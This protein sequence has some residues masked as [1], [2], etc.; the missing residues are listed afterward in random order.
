VTEAFNPYRQ[1]LDLTVSE[2][3]SSDYELLGLK[4]YETDPAVIL[5]AADRAIARVRSHRPGDQAAAWSRLLDDLAAARKRL[6]DPGEKARYDEQLRSQGGSLASPGEAKPISEPSKSQANDFRYPPG[7]SGPGMPVTTGNAALGGGAGLNNG[8]YSAVANAGV[9]VQQPISTPQASYPQQ[10]TPQLAAPWG[11]PPYAPMPSGFPAAAAYPQPMQPMGGMPGYG[12]PAAPQGSYGQSYNPQG[13]YAPGGHPQAMPM[14]APGWP[15]PGA[16]STPMPPP[17]APPAPSSTA[18]PS[19]LATPV[20]TII[21]PMAPVDPMTP[22]GQTPVSAIPVGTAV[23]EAGQGGGLLS[24]HAMASGLPSPSATDDAGVAKFKSPSARQVAVARTR[25]S[26]HAPLVWGAV[27]A[28]LFLVVA[29]VWANLDGGKAIDDTPEVA[30]TP[31]QTR[32]TEIRPREVASPS[33]SEPVTPRPRPQPQPPAPMPEPEMRPVDPMPMRPE[34]PVPQPMPMPPSADPAPMPSPEPEPAPKPEP[35]PP[36]LPTQQEV[37]ELAK[38]LTTARLAL[39]EGNMEEAKKQVAL[40][41]KLPKL[42]EHEAMYGRMVMLVDY[43][44][45]FWD[46][47]KEAVK[48]LESGSELAV[49][50]QVLIVVEVLSDKIILRIAGQNRTYPYEDLPGGIVVAIAD[51][52]LNQNDPTS[53]VM[54]GAYAAVNKAGNVERARQMWDDAI[55]GG[56][57]VRAIL[58]VLDDKYDALA[59]DLEKAEAARKP[60]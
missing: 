33:P 21:D 31:P 1:W 43:N 10:A 48:S 3:P 5:A 6:T 27:C 52:W 8:G 60:Q 49:G 55:R 26:P 46:A 16:E 24:P 34:V 58:P 38:A 7:M 12:Q 14:S 50:S 53:L 2:R 30:K 18:A 39:S 51:K 45:Q 22:T 13:G 47:V 25:T 35:P 15:M 59:K 9:P 17:P 40:A 36:P 42:P 37:A 19:M 23:R 57:D 28:S 56:V 4:L 20:A 11:A 29:F 41:E 44:G 54:K 32:V